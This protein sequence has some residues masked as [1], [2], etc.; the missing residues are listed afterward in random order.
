MPDGHNNKKDKGEPTTPWCQRCLR[1]LSW[2]VFS[3]KAVGK[4]G[5][6]D[7]SEIADHTEGVVH[8]LSFVVVEHQ[9]FG[10]EKHQNS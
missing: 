6:Q 9:F 7:S 8:R 1:P 3:K 4:H 5:S 2:P 10:E